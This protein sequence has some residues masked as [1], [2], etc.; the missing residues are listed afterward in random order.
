MVQIFS[1]S[2]TIQKYLAL[3]SHELFFPPMPKLFLVLLLFEKLDYLNFK[4]FTDQLK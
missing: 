2:T 4:A 3:E 1:R